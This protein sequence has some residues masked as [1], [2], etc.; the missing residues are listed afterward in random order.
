M[1]PRPAPRDPAQAKAQ[2]QAMGIP[3]EILREAVDQAWRATARCTEHDVLSMEGFLAWGVPIRF[4]RDKLCPLGWSVDRTNLETVVSP[5]GLIAL[6]SARGNSHTGDPDRMPSTMTEK[7]PHTQ[8][9]IVNNQLSFDD[10]H[11]AR[12]R[13]R[14]QPAVETW[15]LLQ[16]HDVKDEEIRMELSRGMRFTSSTSRR[17]HGVIS[18]FE[19]RIYLDSIN[20]ANG[21]AD[22]QGHEATA[23]E[24]IDIP[25]N[26]RQTS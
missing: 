21:A 2:L 13:D 4:L 16:Y 24:Q 7:G 20:V 11:T 5:N 18:H 15:F 8:T 1:L 3:P 26:R 10:L 17:D 9:V 23:D 25:V 19:P 6:A 22:A 14:E 12:G